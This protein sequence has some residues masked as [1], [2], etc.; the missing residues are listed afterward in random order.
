MKVIIEGKRYD[1]D[2]AILVGEYGTP[3]LGTSDF[4]YWEA[5][6]Y[7]TPRSGAFFLAGKGH[8]MTPYGSTYADGMRGWG[9]R[10]I[11][12]SREEALEWAEE[13]LS[14]DVIEEH[15]ADMIK[16]A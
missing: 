8:G 11:P 7:K 3:G 16:D 2:K 15:F 13:H 6:L 5:G 12:L 10:I 9:S 1:T 4:R 14:P